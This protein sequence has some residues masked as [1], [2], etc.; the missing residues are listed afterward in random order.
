VTEYDYDQIAWGAGI[1]IATSQDTEVYGNLV[2]DNYNGITVTQQDRYEPPG[3]TYFMR[4]GEW[5]AYNNVIHNNTII[6]SGSNGA[7]E[8]DGDD[9]LFGNNSWYGNTYVGQGDFAWNNQWGDLAYWQGFHP[10]DGV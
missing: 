7:V 4:Y 1:I 6:N 5:R 3:G 10:L 9:T 2:E 8:D